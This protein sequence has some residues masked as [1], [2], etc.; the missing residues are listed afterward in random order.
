MGNAASST[1]EMLRA[2]RISPRRRPYSA[3]VEGELGDLE[4]ERPSRARSL[5]PS[6][7]AGVG[8]ARLSGGRPPA[9]RRPKV[10]RLIEGHAAPG[11]AH[12][13]PDERVVVVAGL[14]RASA[15]TRRCVDFA[16]CAAP[17]SVRDAVETETPARLAT[18]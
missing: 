5:P 4:S 14:P 12:H 2:L 8:V 17:L 3:R 6:C 13:L 9:S 11:G 7:G 1:P 16:T 10:P 18:R 15:I